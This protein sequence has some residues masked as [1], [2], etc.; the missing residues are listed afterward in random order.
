M[1]TNS[2][3]ESS[4][5]Y[6]PTMNLFCVRVEVS[7]DVHGPLFITEKGFLQAGSG[8][9]RLLAR[10]KL[11]EH[12]HPV[13]VPSGIDLSSPDSPQSDRLVACKKSFNPSTIAQAIAWLDRAVKGEA[14]LTLC[15][16]A[17]YP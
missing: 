11:K 6:L 3:R 4:A 16:E 1:L 10:H 2:T 5:R 15:W 12:E 14:R 9:R 7:N 17:A 8:P 13:E